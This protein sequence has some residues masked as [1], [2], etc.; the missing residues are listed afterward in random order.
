MTTLDPLCNVSEVLMIEYMAQIDR[1]LEQ[2]ERLVGESPLQMF[3]KDMRA[4]YNRKFPEDLRARA[5]ALWRSEARRGP[6]QRLTRLFSK[7]QTQ[8]L[9]GSL[10]SE[11]HQSL[12][13]VPGPF[14]NIK[15]TSIT[16][17]LS[18]LSWRSGGEFGHRTHHGSQ[19]CSNNA[20]HSRDNSTTTIIIEENEEPI[21]QSA[22]HM[23]S[24]TNLSRLSMQPSDT[25]VRPH[26]SMS[27]RFSSMK[28]LGSVFG[29][30]RS[31]TAS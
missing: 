26:T 10:S 19:R 9:P 22:S 28:K 15:D 5:E 7:P 25:S 17:R 29:H 30:S 11:A 27:K 23:Q 6:S 13:D 16:G 8:T 12:G 14:A 1:G 24:E 31:I 18:S 4:R 20:R 2:H 21:A 3:N